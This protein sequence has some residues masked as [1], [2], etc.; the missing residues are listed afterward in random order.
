MAYNQNARVLQS[1]PRKISK[2]FDDLSRE[3][4][5]ACEKPFKRR[6]SSMHILGR[7]LKTIILNTAVPNYTF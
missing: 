3:D 7:T 1:H 6:E 4:P 2:I 5:A